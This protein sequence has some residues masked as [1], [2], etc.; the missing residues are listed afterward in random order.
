MYSGM[1]QKDA[2]IGSSTVSCVTTTLLAFIEAIFV[3]AYKMFKQ[4]SEH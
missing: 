3:T 1:L 2:A 4:F